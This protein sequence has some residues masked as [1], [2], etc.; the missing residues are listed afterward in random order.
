MVGALG[1]WKEGYWIP[2]I[3]VVSYKDTSR[4]VFEYLADGTV[5]EMAVA[6]TAEYSYTVPTGYVLDIARINMKLFGSSIRINRWGGSAI[7]NGCLIQIRDAEGSVLEH[8]G[9]D[10]ESLTKLGD[11]AC[12]A[13]VDGIIIGGTGDDIFQLRWTISKAGAKMRLTEDQSF[14]FKTQDSLAGN[15]EQMMMLQGVLTEAE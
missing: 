2:D 15:T 9:T 4:F 14:V 10:K 3:G 8:F 7:T 12:L 5:I 11:F 13:G 6:G 1:A